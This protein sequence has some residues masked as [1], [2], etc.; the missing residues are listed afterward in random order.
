MKTIWFEDNKLKI[1]NQN[2]LPLKLEIKECSTTE[3]VAESIKVLDVR[4]APS[5]GCA[6][7][8]GMAL[9]KINGDDLQEAAA[10]LKATRPTAVNLA[11]AV[12]RC[13]KAGDQV[14]E[15]NKILKEETETCKKIG[16][17]GAKLIA[18]GSNI[19][20]HCN[21]GR[22]ACPDFGTALSPIYNAHAA[23][24]KLH[25]YVD[26]TRP[27]LQGARLTTWELAEAGVP[28]TLITD[29]MAA[30]L[31]QKNKISLAITDADRIASNGDAANKIGTYSLAVNCHHHKI[32]FHVAA[33]TS[34]IDMSLKSGDQ[35][36][37]EE[38]DPDE[39]RLINNKPIAPEC[40]V[41]NPAFDVTPASLI[42]SI[43]TE[44]GIFKPSELAKTF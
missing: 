25:V 33:P 23:G 12:D 6:A 15:A 17:H 18:E 7:A 2:K 37:I 4:G 26:E 44:K 8:F 34:T 21:A 40:D 1:I 39:V 19:I 41:W 10:L 36:P 32:P 38:R 24:T 22:L 20:T 16:E 43:I 27:F 3:Q 28:F 30:Y 42:T 9:A 29:N 31:M 13:L 5:I 35:I 11:W 14:S